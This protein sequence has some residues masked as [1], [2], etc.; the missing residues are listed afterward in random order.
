MTVTANASREPIRNLTT[1]TART[2]T[3]KLSALGAGICRAVS[4]AILGTADVLKIQT[5]PAEPE[6]LDALKSDAIQL[7]VGISPS[8]SPAVQ[9]SVGFGPAV[10]YDSQ[11]IMVAKSSGITDLSGLRNQLIC[12]RYDAAGADAA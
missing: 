2:S 8:T 7:A 5:F 4:A 10:S 3:A 11:R 6:A 1:G 12:T 9:Y